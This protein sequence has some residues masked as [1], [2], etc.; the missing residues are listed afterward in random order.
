MTE[1]TQFRL[2]CDIG[3]TFTDIVLLDCAN[4]TVHLHKQLTTPEEPADGVLQGIKAV[5]AQFPAAQGAIDDVVHASTLAN[6]LVL[7]RKGGPVGLLATE[8]FRDLLEM[9]R[10]ERY[11]MYD[12]LLDVPKPLVP[13]RFRKGINER[14]SAAGE[15]LVPLRLKDVDDAIRELV[16]A[17]VTAVAITYLHSYQNPE[18]ELRT[19]E[20]IAEVAPHLSVSLS[21]RVLPEIREYER[22][23]TTVVDAYVK[24]CVVRYLDSL[25]RKLDESGLRPLRIMLSG[26]SVVSAK[27][28]RDHPVRL[29]ESG[30][31]AG[32]IAAQYYAGLRGIPNCLAFD[33]GGTT[34]KAGLVSSGLPLKTSTYEIDHVRRFKKGS[35][36]PIQLPA[37]NLLEV[38]AGG[39]SIARIDRLGLLEV[40]P[41]S[42]GAVPGPACYGRGGTLPTV[43]D[44]DLLLGYIDAFSFASGQMRLSTAAAETAIQEKV[45]KP[46]ALST[47][48]AAKGIHDLINER[49]AVAIR[50]YCLENGE[51]PVGLSLV[52]TGGAG[53]IHAYGVAKKLGIRKVIVPA[54]AGVMSAVG[55]LTA[56]PGFDV[57]RTI[58]KQLHQITEKEIDLLLAQMISEAAV[59]LEASAESLSISSLAADMR[60]SG[61]G[62]EIAVPLPTSGKCVALDQLRGAFESSYERLY[63]HFFRDLSIE[64]ISIR[65]AAR[66]PSKSYSSL[67]RSGGKSID[68][69][70]NAVRPVHFPGESHALRARVF[71][72]N[73]LTPNQEARGPAIVTFPET[74]AIVGPGAYFRVDEYRGLSITLE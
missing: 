55:L 25:E 66:L 51:D 21:C 57:V 71:D 1:S 17:G 35:G 18:H 50:M 3:G 70:T 62:F 46:L 61:Q 48:N 58:K 12:I 29:I 9:R 54:V 72:F 64:I 69:L 28:G 74:T 6:N 31:S 44:A 43:S 41:D 39:G 67:Q 7:E 38:G 49:M 34:A 8:G 68:E 45:A 13:R 56:H 26:G 30:P 52:A 23:S 20:R 2:S 10:Q 33:I 40:G 4:G 53:P 73:D 32:V 59:A 60:Y 16:A 14:I 65:L 27:T 22:T 42:A 37:I 24:P 36:I 11:D 5:L 15:V 47:I 19:A 63:G